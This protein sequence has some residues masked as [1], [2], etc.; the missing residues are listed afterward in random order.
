MCSIESIRHSS[1]STK[2]KLS[3]RTIPLKMIE[4]RLHHLKEE[5][6]VLTT[7]EI[8]NSEQQIEQNDDHHAQYKKRLDQLLRL[9]DKQ[10]NNLNLWHYERCNTIEKMYAHELRQSDETFQMKKIDFK[11]KL[12]STFNDKRRH[13]E[14]EHQNVNIRHRHNSDNE[15]FLLNGIHNHINDTNVYDGHNHQS[16]E[17]TQQQ[18]QQRPAYN[19]RRAAAND[20]LTENSTSSTVTSLKDL[21]IFSGTSSL[22]P[23]FGGIELQRCL[24]NTDIEQDI[25]DICY[26]LKHIEPIDEKKS[27]ENQH[28]DPST[29]SLI[30]VRIEEGR[31]W[32]QRAWFSRNSPI[33]L[34]FDDLEIV[35][36][37]VLTVGRN[38]LLVRRSGTNIKHRVSL[39]LLHDGH[40]AI[41]KRGCIF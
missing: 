37:L 20:I 28:D 11:S 22:L 31:L 35:P 33:L 16:N 5:L 9:Y 1:H 8:I 15:Q 12:L 21:S 32:Y 41:R 18:L 19:L 13:L 36:A 17:S 3:N 38:D 4:K 27:S 34:V 7:K 24:S 14:Y 39:S 26:G 40:L 6:R 25:K 29:K 23:P 2:N 30:D 10:I